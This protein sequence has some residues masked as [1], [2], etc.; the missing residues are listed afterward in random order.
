VG[1]G[2]T[3]GLPYTGAEPTTDVGAPQLR[4][5][6]GWHPQPSE[7]LRCGY[8]PLLLSWLPASLNL[9]CT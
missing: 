4:V 6:P 1:G 8:E 3:P 2:P 9:L 5:A 7:S